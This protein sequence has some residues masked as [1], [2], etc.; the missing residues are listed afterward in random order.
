MTSSTFHRSPS[1]ISR[2]DHTPPAKAGVHRSSTKSLRRRLILPLTLRSSHKYISVGI[3]WPSTHILTSRVRVADDSYRH[4]RRF[5][6][7]R[8]RGEGSGPSP[9]PPPHPKWARLIY[10]SH[11]HESAPVKN[12]VTCCLATGGGWA[13]AHTVCTGVKLRR[14]A[15]AKILS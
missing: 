9:P 11:L 4:F 3:W 14:I 1:P 13:W 2:H 7:S 5:R 10:L 6:H 8:H 15:V 12:R